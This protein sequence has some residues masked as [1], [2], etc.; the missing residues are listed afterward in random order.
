MRGVEYEIIVVANKSNSVR[1]AQFGERESKNGA[2]FL[3]ANFIM[4]CSKLT[5]ELP[6]AP[7][8]QNSCTGRRAWI[9]KR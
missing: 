9:A 2:S 8:T 5:K 1:A 7:L 4:L 3:S 6:K